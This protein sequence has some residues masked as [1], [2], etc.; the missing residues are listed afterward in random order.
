MMSCPDS[1]GTVSG[2]WPQQQLY[3]DLVSILGDLVCVSVIA[4]YSLAHCFPF[5]SLRLVC[6]FFPFASA[7]SRSTL[8]RSSSPLAGSSFGS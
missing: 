6:A 8:I 4:I 1:D 5:L 7:A 3:N 2:E